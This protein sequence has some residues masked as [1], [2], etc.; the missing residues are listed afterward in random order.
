MFSTNRFVCN[1]AD[2]KR[3]AQF[4]AGLYATLSAR[5]RPEDVAQMVLELLGSR[6]S[7][8]EQAV[9]NRAAQSSLKQSAWSYSSMM[10]EFLRPAPMVRQ[11]KKAGELF[12]A[13][14]VLSPDDCAN[15]T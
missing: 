11:V 15:P 8:D 2:M 10:Q 12:D 9:L 4:L 1:K 13:A 6:L 5:K 3:D 14:P 7:G